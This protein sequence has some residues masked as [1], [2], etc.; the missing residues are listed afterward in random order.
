MFE[1]FIEST[2][3]SFSRL[4]IRW[5]EGLEGACEAKEVGLLQTNQVLA[6]LYVLLLWPL[7][8]TATSIQGKKLVSGRV[9]CFKSKNCGLHVR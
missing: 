6:V 9:P 1:L 5:G 3:H 8:T 2:Y 7:R 4:V